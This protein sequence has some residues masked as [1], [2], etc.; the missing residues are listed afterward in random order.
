MKWSEASLTGLPM[1]Q[2]P[3]CSTC[4]FALWTPI[5]KLSV[6][7]VG[8]YDDAR[9]P[10]RLIVS[11]DEH[12]EHFDQA[13][14]GVLAAFMADLQVA[15]LVLRKMGDVE[16]VNIA[17]LG[18]KDPHVHAHVIPRRVTDA[19]FGVAPWENAE[20]RSSMTP[21]DRVTIVDLLRQGFGVVVA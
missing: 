4:G 3:T 10:G 21:E 1:K 5:A 11:L 16:R 17:V 13:D 2:Q 18:N 7:H 20:P 12:V 15:S 8:L 6:S 9:F 14:P 19:N